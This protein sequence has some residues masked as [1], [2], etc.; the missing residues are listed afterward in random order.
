L[1]L[2]KYYEWSL[3]KTDEFKD[4]IPDLFTKPNKAAL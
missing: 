2:S 4:E 3:P 1:N